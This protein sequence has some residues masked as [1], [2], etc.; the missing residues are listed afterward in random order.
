MDDS[1]VEYIREELLEL[2]EVRSK[3]MFSSVGLYLGNIFFG[4]VH[5]GTLYIKT[6]SSKTAEKYITAGMKAF[7]PSDTQV[8]KNYL[9]IPP[10]MLE[11]RDEFLRYAEEACEV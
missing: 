11:N 1:F 7:V 8:L 10:E 4:I 6:T 2:G 9:E 5:N 3:K